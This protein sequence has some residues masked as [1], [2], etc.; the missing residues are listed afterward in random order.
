MDKQLIIVVT[1]EQADQRIDKFLAQAEQI[2]T[3]NRAH[4]L[5][6]NGCVLINF[7]HLI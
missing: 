3:R 1:A 2:T 7:N 4:H 6:E 5:I